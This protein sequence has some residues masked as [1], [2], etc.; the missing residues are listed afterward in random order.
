MM[1]PNA[2]IN[3]RMNRTGLKSKL[4]GKEFLGSGIGESC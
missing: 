1:I 2:A 4:E 3:P